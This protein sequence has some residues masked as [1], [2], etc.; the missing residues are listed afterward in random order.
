LT[1]AEA[2]QFKF[3]FETEFD[4]WSVTCSNMKNLYKTFRYAALI[5]NAVF[6]LWIII[7]GID[8]GFKGTLVEICSYVVLL[9]L[10]AVNFVLIYKRP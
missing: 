10:L 3:L 9:A 7:N 6:F 2:T 8:E 5:G 4:L 1:S